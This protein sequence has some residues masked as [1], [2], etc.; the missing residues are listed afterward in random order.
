MRIL[1]Y[2]LGT[3]LALS[4]TVAQGQITLSESMLHAISSAKEKSEPLKNKQIEIEKLK[5]QQKEVG[6]KRLPSVAATGG[7]FVMHSK[8][9]IDLEPT[10]TP[11]FPKPLFT[12]VKN[13]STHAHG[14]FAGVNAQV[15]LFSGMQIP[16]AQK[17]LEQ[18]RIGTEY[19]NENATE[20][21]V[22]E[23]V[24]SFDQIEVLNAI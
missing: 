11:F 15:V 3:G 4:A 1:K 5:L 23:V 13:S 22:Q 21:L 20:D 14:A 16:Y 10:Q 8:S 7:Y 2:L 19:L 18:K 6:D 12:G 9:S 17:A 24:V